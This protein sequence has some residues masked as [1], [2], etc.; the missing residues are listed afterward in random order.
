MN[1]L[2]LGW[3]EIVFILLLALVLFSPQEAARFAKAIGRGLNR[4]A[5]SETWHMLRRT[6]EELRALPNRLLKEATLDELAETAQRELRGMPGL[7][8]LASPPERSDL[9]S[10]ATETEAPNQEAS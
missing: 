1:F 2:G 7:T 6:S 9:A 10:E 4:L 5:H 8:P 3:E